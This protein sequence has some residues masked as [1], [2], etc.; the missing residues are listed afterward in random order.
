MP[1]QAD[2]LIPTR[3]SLLRRLKD[4][5]DQAGWQLFFD[6]YWKLI[7]NVALKS[8]CTEVEA[9]DAVQETFFAVAKHIPTFKYDPKLGSFK[10]W[11]LNMA[12][13]RIVDQLRKRGPV[14]Q[15]RQRSAN[16]AT[17]ARTDTVEAIADPSG[18]AL[19]RL[20]ESEWYANL[21]AAATTNVKRRLEPQKYQIFDCYVNK[22]WAPEKVARAFGLSVGNVY[23]ATH[24]IKQ[25][26]KNEVMR[27][28]K[29]LY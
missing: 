26:V 17:E 5:E 6:T 16:P 1:G 28:E 22:G 24:R 21:L 19:E 27:L 25:L 14:S 10:T 29:E 9:Q 20:W 23:V 15:R 2:E 7:Y 3:T 18:N 11:L 13:W 12:R 4:W 8:G